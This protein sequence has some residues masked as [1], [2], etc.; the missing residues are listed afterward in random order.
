MRLPS[1]RM[2][3]SVRHARPRVAHAQAGGHV[4]AR[5]ATFSAKCVHA[6]RF[7]RRT[8][9]IARKCANFFACR[10]RL[11][12]HR[13][14]STRAAACAAASAGPAWRRRGMHAQLRPPAGDDDRDRYPEAGRA[15]W[16]RWP[17]GA[18][19][20]SGVEHDAAMAVRP[21]CLCRR[22]DDGPRVLFDA[23]HDAGLR[24]AWLSCR[25]WRVRRWRRIRACRRGVADRAARVRA[26]HAAR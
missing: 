23:V 1:S 4:R 21:S 2:A 3:A 26:G 22:H 20:R 11:V 14:P 10:T 16:C 9:P 6:S 24:G 15:A 19:G 5:A 25:P 17:G 8:S 18:V 12:M 13:A 7:W